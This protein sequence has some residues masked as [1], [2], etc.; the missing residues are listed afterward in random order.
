MPKSACY[1]E[2]VRRRNRATTTSA[3]GG[4]LSVDSTRVDSTRVDMSCAQAP[5]LGALAVGAS[6]L[7]HRVDAVLA[8]QRRMAELGLRPGV[9]V[10]VLGRTA[11]GGRL[12]GVGTDRIALD[13]A[14]AGRVVVAA[15]R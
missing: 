8:Q 12:L 10:T 1:G 5:V 15:T 14:T 4:R 11:G 6:G 7:V 3:H 9:V 2:R 13:G